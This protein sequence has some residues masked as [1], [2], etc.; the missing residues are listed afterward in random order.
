[1]RSMD[2][3]AASSIKTPQPVLDASRGS[4]GIEKKKPPI[5]MRAQRMLTGTSHSVCGLIGGGRCS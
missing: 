5:D 2:T 1:M 3:A 4:V